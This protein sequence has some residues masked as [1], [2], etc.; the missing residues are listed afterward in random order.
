MFRGVSKLKKAAVNMLVK[1][2]DHEEIESLKKE[3]E[4]IDVDNSGLISAQELTDA[5]L[6][7]N[8]ELE[9]TK[10]EEIIKEVDVHDNK[11]INYHEFIAAT[12]ESQY[13]Q[14][15]KTLMALYNQ[16]DTDKSGNITKENIVTAMNKMGY[17]LT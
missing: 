3:F 15:E 12:I 13:Y 16:F 7:I 8:S 6:R 9:K 5:Y 1:M 14:D 2:V 4:K 10:I 11:E 17:D